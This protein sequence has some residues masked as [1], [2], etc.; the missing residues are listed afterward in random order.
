MGWRG[1]LSNWVPEAT[2][3]P[4]TATFFLPPGCSGTSPRRL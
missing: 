4:Q 3:S 1:A 2:S